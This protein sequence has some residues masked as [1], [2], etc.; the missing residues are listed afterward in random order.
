MDVPWMGVGDV[1][2]KDESDLT[3]AEDNPREPNV[4]LLLGTL[5]CSPSAILMN[6]KKIAKA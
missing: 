6:V 2:R 4:L 1:I 3:S 5:D